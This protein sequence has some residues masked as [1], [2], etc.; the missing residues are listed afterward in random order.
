VVLVVDVGGNW[1]ANSGGMGR[2]FPY[3]C[4]AMIDTK[5]YDSTS[6]YP[7]KTIYTW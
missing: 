5:L 3:S 2:V 7:S 1:K 6:K 4:S